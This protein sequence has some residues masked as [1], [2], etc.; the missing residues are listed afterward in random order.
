MLFFEPPPG[1]DCGDEF[2]GVELCLEFVDDRR[3]D[4]S[5]RAAL[6]TGLVT[7]EQGLKASFPNGRQPTEQMTAGNAAIIGDLR[8]CVLSPGGEFDGQKAVLAPAVLF[9]GVFFINDG[10]HIGPAK[11]KRVSC[12]A[13]KYQAI[14]ISSLYLRKMVLVS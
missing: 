7:L 2:A 9:G 10:G 13:R 12:H 5:W 6:G 14:G 1:V 11:S 4:I 8:G 3:G